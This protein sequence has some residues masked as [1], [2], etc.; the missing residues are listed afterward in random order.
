MQAENPGKI[1][2]Q[3]ID[4]YIP[5]L[6]LKY[7]W[8]VVSFV[9]TQ[10]FTR[11]ESGLL[12]GGECSHVSLTRARSSFFVPLCEKK[13]FK[14]LPMVDFHFYYIFFVLWDSWILTFL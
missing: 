12:I 7:V 3:N 5:D 10:K 4:I 9:H 13:I 8:K 2:H 11:R 1:W 14:C 6:N